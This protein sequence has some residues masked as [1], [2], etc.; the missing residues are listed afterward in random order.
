[1]GEPA[2]TTQPP[3]VFFTIPDLTNRLPCNKSSFPIENLLDLTRCTTTPVR[4]AEDEALDLY[5]CLSDS[6]TKGLTGPDT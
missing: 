6:K 2:V 4:N 1:M 5:L 3:P